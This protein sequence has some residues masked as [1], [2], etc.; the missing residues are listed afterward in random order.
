MRQNI[1][2]ENSLF[3]IEGRE[4]SSGKARTDFEE[5]LAQYTRQRL[6]LASQARDL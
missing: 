3:P 5:A 1:R 4:K 2:K 6:S